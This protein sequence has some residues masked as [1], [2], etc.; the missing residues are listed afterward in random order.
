MEISDLL[1]LTPDDP[2]SIKTDGPA[3]AAALWSYQK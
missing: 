3:E 1:D 2:Y